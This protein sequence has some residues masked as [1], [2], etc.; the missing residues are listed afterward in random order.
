MNVAFMLSGTITPTGFPFNASYIQSK[1]DPI[2]DL[3]KT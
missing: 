2:V 3:T 1:G